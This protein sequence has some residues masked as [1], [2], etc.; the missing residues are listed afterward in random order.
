MWWFIPLFS[1]VLTIVALFTAKPERKR[2]AVV[3]AVCVFLVLLS[4]KR[5]HPTKTKKTK[6]PS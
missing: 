5:I 1:A 3:Y 4:F 2:L 6:E